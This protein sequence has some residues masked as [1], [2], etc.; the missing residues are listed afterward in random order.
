MS[1]LNFGQNGD[2]L[3]LKRVDA[4]NGTYGA[5]RLPERQPGNDGGQ[6]IEYLHIIRRH[7]LLILVWALIGIA[8]GALLSLLAAPMYRARTTLDI[9]QFNQDILNGK[10]Q[11]NS[12]DGAPAES[13]IQTEIKI[14]QSE[15]MVR[16]ATAKLKK[17]PARSDGGGD[18]AVASWSRGFG[19]PAPPKFKPDVLLDGISRG[20]KVRTLGLT[21]IVEVIC[22]A[23]DARVAA[24]FCKTLA[25][26][27]I[28]QNSEAR[29]Q[30]TQQTGEW[31]SHQLEDLKHRLARSEEQL[32]QSA[33]ATTGALVLAE[34]PSLAQEKLRQLQNELSSA[35]AE[36]LTNRR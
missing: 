31:L 19:L 14:L 9:Q 18:S 29:W 35:R 28:A 13:Y 36:R 10:P 21:R 4:G 34:D 5:P 8:A 26:E 12:N 23:P 17:A 16:R 2:V 32:T 11:T 33:K 15:S 6:L 3:V 27:Y 1:N 25:D 30:S 7:I 20:L 24:A 22:D